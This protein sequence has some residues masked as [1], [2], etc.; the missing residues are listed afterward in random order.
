MGRSFGGG[1]SGGGRS[2]GFSGGGR[3]FGGF[4]GG[5]GRGRSFG[6]GRSG[7]FGG[8]GRPR[9]PRPGYS[10]GGSF[11]PFMAGFGL[12]RSTGGGGPVGT[13][14]GGRGN[15][16]CVGG[17]GTIL[18]IIVVLAFISALFA[19][20]SSCSSSALSTD[21]AAST[22]AREPLPA[23]AAE[24]TSTHYLDEDGGWISDVNEFERGMR[25]F[26]DETGVEPFVY[27]LPNGSVT[28]TAELGQIAQQ[29]YDQLFDDEAHFLLVFCDDDRG[30]FNCGYAVGSQAKTVMD[31]EAIGILSDYLDRY[32]Q[33]L[34]L[35]EEEIFSRAFADTGERIMSK[36]T[37]PVVYVAICAA[38]VIV[39]VLI[40][41]G[42]KKY[43][44]SKEREAEKME[45]VLNTPLETFGDAHLD[46][47]EKKYSDSSDDDA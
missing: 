40:F 39:A 11:L 33:D 5:G 27:I 16:G 46:D 12:G 38:V 13:P 9:P 36:T 23:G 31:S 42:V 45:E 7:G 21:V 43:R 41:T 10:G 4:S 44:E 34:S 22:V 26:A 17:C 8:F 14:G 29:A 32:Y 15:A 20:F 1:R 19:T 37:S 30:S 2:G 47:L 24:T 25:A 28:S 35:S 3:S 6:G 18:G